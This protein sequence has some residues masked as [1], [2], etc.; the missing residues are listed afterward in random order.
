M[1]HDISDCVHVVYEG[2]GYSRTT[3][4]IKL[5]DPVKSDYTFDITVTDFGNQAAKFEGTMNWQ[6][7]D[8]EWTGQCISKGKVDREVTEISLPKPAG[9][10]GTLQE[11]RDISPLAWKNEGKDIPRG[12]DLAQL[13]GDEVMQKITVHA[14]DDETKRTLFP[15]QPPLSPAE[16]SILADSRDYFKR[17]AVHLIAEQLKKIHQIN[18]KISKGSSVGFQTEFDQTV[19]KHITYKWKTFMSMMTSFAPPTDGKPDPVV[20]Y[21][22]DRTKDAE[23]I[24]RLQSQFQ[25]AS[26]RCYLEGYKLRF[27]EWDKFLK[28]PVYWFKCFSSLLVSPEHCNRWVHTLIDPLQN[29]NKNAVTANQEVLLWG[30][31]LSVLK[32]ASPKEVRD[33]LDIGEVTEYLT[34]QAQLALAHAQ[35]VNNDLVESTKRVGCISAIDMAA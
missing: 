32:Q 22:W 12:T 16:S 35:L 29:T 10:E 8:Y 33:Q 7:I 15:S 31:K 18:P 11:L 19:V 26:M 1:E 9:L 17:A 23:L 2:P 21:G 24:I 3:R 30:N 6:G 4:F 13:K 25:E 34:S 20:E 14:L 5:R 27:P 28:H